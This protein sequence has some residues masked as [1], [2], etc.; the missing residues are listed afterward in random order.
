MRKS[1]VEHD[2]EQVY[3]GTVTYSC[4]EQCSRMHVERR[5]KNGVGRYKTIK[6]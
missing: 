3:G 1:K 5:G 4:T 2:V 6:E